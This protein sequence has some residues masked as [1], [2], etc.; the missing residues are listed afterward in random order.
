VGYV[1]DLRA[2]VGQRPLI[3]AGADVLPINAAGRVLLHLRADNP[4]WGLIGG[5]M[6]PGES[7]EDTARRE[8]REEIGLEAGALTPFCVYS[9]PAFVYRYPNGD[10]AFHVGVV[11]L[12]RE[13]L[14]TPH[15]KPDEALEVRYFHLDALP[16]ALTPGAREVLARY[17]ARTS[18]DEA[19]STVAP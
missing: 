9:G 16:A 1:E 19:Q 15:L 17:R 5:S 14:G 12:V 2:L 18:G 13:L 4:E 8:L 10:V 3:L 7:F 11:F 6:E